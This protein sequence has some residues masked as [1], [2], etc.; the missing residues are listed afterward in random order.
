MWNKIPFLGWFLSAVSAISLSVPFWLCWTIGGLGEK[1]FSWL[2]LVYQSISF[3]NCVG[4]FIVIAIIKGTLT[5]KLF[6]VSN[7]QNVN[8]G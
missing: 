4:L 8:Q 2:P 3:W 1:Y 5:P 6:S 7:S